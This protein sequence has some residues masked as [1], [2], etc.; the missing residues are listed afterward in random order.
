MAICWH[1][2]LIAEPIADLIAALISELID[3]L[4]AVLNAHP[5]APALA[6]PVRTGPG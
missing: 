2:V 4:I 5:P 1:S 3:A 6:I